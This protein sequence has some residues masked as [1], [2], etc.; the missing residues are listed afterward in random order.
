MR[1]NDD[2]M[3]DVIVMNED[4]PCRVERMTRK[5]WVYDRMQEDTE[6]YWRD[7]LYYGHAYAHRR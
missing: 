3:I 7:V 4:G 2:E 6:R 5:E 1:D